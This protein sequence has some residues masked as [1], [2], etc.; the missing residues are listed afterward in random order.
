MKLTVGAVG[1]PGTTAPNRTGDW[2][3]LHPEFL[4]EKC[5]GCSLCA[6]A[7][8]EGCVTGDPKAKKFDYDA[9]YC[10]GCG[11]CV[12]VCPVGDIRMVAETR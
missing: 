11:L 4:H 5:A 10:K 12:A 6:M 7:C 3:V 1:R 8:P 2:R 9:Y